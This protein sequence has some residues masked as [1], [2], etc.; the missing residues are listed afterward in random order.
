MDSAA[1]F[2]SDAPL[3]SRRAIIRQNPDGVQEI[4]MIEATWGPNPRLSDGDS[5]RFVR[6][7]GQT[8]PSAIIHRR[9]VMQWL[10]RIIPAID[11]L[12]TPPARTFI[13]EPIGAGARQPMLAL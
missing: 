11:L 5:Y 3:G 12:A 9:Q 10:D 8:F 1:P 2:D 7:E 4:E 13:V 6:S